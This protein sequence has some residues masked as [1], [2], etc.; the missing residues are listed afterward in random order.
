[1]GRPLGVA[2]VEDERGRHRPQLD[3]DRRRP[4]GEAERGRQR[5]AQA[6]RQG[7]EQV[8]APEDGGRDQMV[9]DQGGE[10]AAAVEAGL[11]E[12][13]QVTELGRVLTGEDDGRRSAE[14]VTLFDSTGLA[15]QDLAIAIAAYAQADAL[16]VPRLTL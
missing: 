12:R 14:D 4:D 9:R 6:G 8:A 7:A 11:V 16:D 15:V 10:L 1:M 3:L 2:V 13:A 5:L